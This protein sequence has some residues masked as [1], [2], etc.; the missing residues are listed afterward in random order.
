V[1]SGAFDEGGASLVGLA[2]R[3][4]LFVPVGGTIMLAAAAAAAAAV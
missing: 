1:L 2:Y 3:V 4:T